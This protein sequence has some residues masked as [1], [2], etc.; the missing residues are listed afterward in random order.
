MLCGYCNTDK[1][2]GLFTPSERNRVIR[3]RGRRLC[4]KCAH[5]RRDLVPNKR[6]RG[7]AWMQG[8]RRFFPSVMSREDG[9]A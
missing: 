8:N 9:L 6:R 7:W 5:E 3:K 1:H 2:P 4:M